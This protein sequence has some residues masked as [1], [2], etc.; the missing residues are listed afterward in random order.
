MSL[1]ISRTADILFSEASFLLGLYNK[2]VAVDRRRDEIRVTTYWLKGFRQREEIIP[3]DRI[4]DVETQFSQSGRRGEIKTYTLVLALKD[5]RER[6]SIASFRGVVYDDRL[7]NLMFFW[8]NADPKDAF[9]DYFDL[10]VKYIGRY[11]VDL[12]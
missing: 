3:F 9:G 1:N 2:K 7:S 4:A 11:E 8:R 12:P 6:I 10:L 5:P